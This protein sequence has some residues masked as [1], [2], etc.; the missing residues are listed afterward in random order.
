MIAAQLELDCGNP[1][2]STTTGPSAGPASQTSK[3]SSPRRNWSNSGLQCSDQAGGI[4]RPLVPLVVDE[5]RR[6]RVQVHQLGVLRVVLHTVQHLRRVHTHV[7][8][9]PFK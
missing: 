1:C 5:E 8:V 7:L 9:E 4:P 6:G 2:N 3:T